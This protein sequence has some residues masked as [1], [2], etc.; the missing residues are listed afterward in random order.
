MVRLSR[1]LLQEAGNRMNTI[2]S[3]FLVCPLSKQPLRHCQETNSLISD[4]LGVS[5]PIKN[6]IPCLVPM[7]G[8]ILETEQDSVTAAA[9]SSV[10]NKD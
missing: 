4:S 7:D 1:T 2:L 8:K 6:G 10:K 9:D 5:Y 3:E